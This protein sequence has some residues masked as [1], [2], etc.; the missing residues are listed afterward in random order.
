MAIQHPAG[1]GRTRRPKAIWNDNAIVTAQKETATTVTV[2]TVANLN[3][4]INDATSGE[5]GYSTENQRYL[6]LHLTGDDDDA[7]TVQVYGYNYAF[8]AWGKLYIPVRGTSAQNSWKVA[9]FNTIDDATGGP[10]HGILDI[11]GIDRIALG[12]G[13]G[14]ISK[15][16]A[17]MA[18]TT[19]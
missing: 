16:T 12:A 1:Y 3:D 13:S 5:N 14:D 18:C 9:T 7:Y 19:F 11:A 6:H 17:R 8:G 15:I 2:V 10:K 4:T